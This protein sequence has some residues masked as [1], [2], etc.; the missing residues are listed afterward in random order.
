MKNTSYDFRHIK[1]EVR[2]ITHRHPT[3]KPDEGFLTW[4]LRAFVVDDEDTARKSLTGKSRDKGID[5]IYTDHDARFCRGVGQSLSP[6]G[7]GGAK[8]LYLSGF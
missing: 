7:G 8:Q 1:T 3:L 2:E 5:G 4:F 6:T